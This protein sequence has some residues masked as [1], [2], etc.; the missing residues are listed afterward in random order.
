MVPLTAAV[1]GVV[2]SVAQRVLP[3]FVAPFGCGLPAWECLVSIYTRGRTPPAAS[4]HSL[5]E[6]LTLAFQIQSAV[7]TRP[8]Q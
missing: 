7:S 2:A 1:G 8:V 4:G 5:I 3:R 6:R